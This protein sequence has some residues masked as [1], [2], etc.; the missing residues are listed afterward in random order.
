MTWKNHIN[1]IQDKALK[2]LANLKRISVRVPRLVKRQVYTSFARPIMEYGSEMFDNCSD[3][4][5]KVLENIQ[6][7]FCLIIT[8]AYKKT[9]SSSLL[10]ECG[11]ESLRSRRKKK[12][13]QVMYK[14][15]NG[16][17]PEYLSLL[18]PPNRDKKSEYKLRAGHNIQQIKTKKTYFYTSFFPSTIREWNNLNTDTQDALSVEVFKSRLKGKINF[19][20][21]YLWCNDH[22][23]INLS[24]IRM[25]LSALKQQRKAFHFIESGSCSYCN[26]NR[27]S[28]SHYF[29]HCP[30]FAAL[31][32]EMLQ[33]LND[34]LQ[35]PTNSLTETKWIELILFGTGNYNEDKKLFETVTKYITKSKRFV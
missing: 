7:Q 33:Y 8:G 25:G 13:L 35:K 1:I 17:A 15:Q 18:C 23:S 4:E 20:K 21:A 2:V 30:N 6:R 31:R 24:R 10:T 5:C 16:H 28:I 3:D 32:I 11:L 22:A 14:I 19:N 29:L 9:K 27:E 34:V 12:K 26:A